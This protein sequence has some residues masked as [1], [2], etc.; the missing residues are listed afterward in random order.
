[1]TWLPQLE[2]FEGSY[3]LE[4][5]ASDSSLHNMGPHCSQPPSLDQAPD[6]GLCGMEDQFI[7]Y[8]ILKASKDSGSDDAQEQPN[9]VE[10]GG[11]PEQVVEVDDIL[12]AADIDVL[13]VPTSDLHTAGQGEA[14][15]S[16]SPGSRLS[17]R[18]LATMQLSKKI[19]RW[20]AIIRDIIAMNVLGEQDTTINQSDCS[21][22]KKR[23]PLLP[24]RETHHH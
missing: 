4:A 9:D 18:A 20:G 5:I 1:M 12:A 13:V 14:H 23:K 10:D 16:Q 21:L 7:P 22:S 8:H 11:R 3:T 15:S 24:T 2:I 17:P 6:R 19:G